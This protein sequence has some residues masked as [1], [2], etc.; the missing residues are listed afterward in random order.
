MSLITADEYA[1][2]QE[3]CKSYPFGLEASGRGK[4]KKIRCKKTHAKLIGEGSPYWLPII[5]CPQKF[6]K[7]RR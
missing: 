4:E 1:K 7:E 6:P 2:I 5:D 3:P